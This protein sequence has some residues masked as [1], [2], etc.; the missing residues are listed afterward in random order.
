[1]SARDSRIRRVRRHARAIGLRLVL[2]RDGSVALFAADGAI[3][4]SGQ[5][6]AAE[7]YLAE[8]YPHKHGRNTGRRRAEPPA[9]TPML[10]DYMLTLSA[11]GRPPTSIELRRIQLARMARELGVPPAE[12]TG[13]M[14]V[15]WFG[16]R[17]EW[18]LETRR[19]ERACV[20]G[21]F[22]WAYQTKRVPDYLGDEL[23][24]VRMPTASPRPAP[25]S[26]WRRA[27]LA[28][29]ARTTLMLR[30][31]AEAGLR[32]GE[33]AQVHTR[34][35]LEGVDGAQLLVHGKGNKQRVVPI[36][37]ALAEAIRRRA[38]GGWLAGGWA[39]GGWLF[40]SWPDGGHLTPNY[41]GILVANVLPDGWTMHTLR[42]RFASRAYR[43]TRNLRAV[44]VLLGHSSIAT[45]ER[46]CA[47][48]DSEIRA[49]MVAAIGD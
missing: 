47:V 6:E 14:L 18:K 25:D 39:A 19:S 10:D 38:A 32:R 22:A 8:H 42:H 17:T 29:D 35:L 48:D 13:E 16:G 24:K 15:A 3:M 21:F 26:A 34:D 4:V 44:Q 41:V 27:L 2:R 12:V 9:W 28:A 1:M 43:G 20:R 40:P 49:A 37:D 5:L 7:S 45:T 11:A 46:Y 33:V 31:A 30:L 36:S 23:P